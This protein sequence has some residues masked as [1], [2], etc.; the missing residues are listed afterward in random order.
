MKKIMI[1]ALASVF[2]LGLGMNAYAQTTQRD[3][4]RSQG[5]SD[6][7]RRDMNQYNTR[8]NKM[9]ES[10]AKFRGEFKGNDLIG[11]G[12]E[13]RNGDNLGKISD[14]A[15]NPENDRVDFAVLEHGATLGLGG[16]YSAVPLSAFSVKMDNNGKVEKLVLDVNKDRLAQMPTFDKDHWPNRS[17]AV[18]SYRFFGQTPYWHGKSEAKK[19]EHRAKSTESTTKY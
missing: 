14:L 5:Y 18:K 9:F 7:E 2:A 10:F 8:D 19:M 13:N 15:V 11:M 16:K 12:V 3:M 4:N 17:E 6:Q 1:T